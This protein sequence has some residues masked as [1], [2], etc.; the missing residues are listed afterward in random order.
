[1]LA[2]GFNQLSAKT[3]LSELKGWFLTPPHS[4]STTQAHPS[5]SLHSQILFWNIEIGNL[6]STPGFL[7]SSDEDHI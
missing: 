3:D 5:S 2:W 1:M 6:P 7:K 4:A